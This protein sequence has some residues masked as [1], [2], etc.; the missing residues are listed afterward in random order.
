MNCIKNYLLIIALI[1]SNVA[2]GQYTDIINSNRPGASSSAF[3]VGTNVLQFEAGPYIIKEKHTPLQNEVSGFGIDFAARYGLLLEELEILIEGTYQN[4]TFKDNRSLITFEDTRSNFKSFTLGA[5]YLVYDPN[6]NAEEDKP[7]LYSWKA[8]RQFKL[9][10][11]IPAVAVYAG[12]NID[13]KNNPYLAPN[14]EGISPKVMVA[15]Q[16]NFASGWVF[17]TNF[18]Y[19]RFT[20]DYPEF[21]YILTLTKSVTEKWVIFGET[22]GISN[23]YYADNLFRLGG[24]YLWNQNFQL[25]TAL[26]FNTKDTPSVFSVNLGASYRFDFHKDKEIDNKNSA[27]EEAER[28][29]NK[30]G[31]NK[32]KK[33][34]DKN[35]DAPK[36][37]D[38][39]EKQQHEV[40]FDD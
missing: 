32:R 6:K 27:E 4:D 30:K 21:Q 36:S 15:T 37:Q 1:V 40:D 18:I 11:L 14:V 10:S 22:Q 29:L 23:D 3:S 28:V 17:V 35:D 2:L 16:N 26:T 8:N 25:D 39:R 31:K 38:K 24:A 7:N 34:R 20:T 13:S 9:K 19:D 5:K 33:R 12:V